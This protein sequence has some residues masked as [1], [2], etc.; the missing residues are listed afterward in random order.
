MPSTCLCILIK[1]IFFIYLPSLIDACPSKEDRLTDT[2]DGKALVAENM[3][4]RNSASAPIGSTM[5][6][7]VIY[8]QKK[9]GQKRRKKMKKGSRIQRQ[10][11]VLLG[12]VERALAV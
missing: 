5:S 9:R 4:T 10:G 12:E 7:P 11:G 8:Q 6:E 3:V 1:Y 2:D